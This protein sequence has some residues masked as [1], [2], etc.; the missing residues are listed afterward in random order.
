MKVRLTYGYIT[1][2]ARTIITRTHD[3]RFRPIYLLHE[4]EKSKIDVGEVGR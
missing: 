3:S 2:R 1:Q 4:G